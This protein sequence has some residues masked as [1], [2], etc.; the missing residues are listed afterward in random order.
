MF[1]GSEGGN[2]TK[3]RAA[4]TTSGALARDVAPQAP[5]ATATRIGMQHAN[6]RRTIGRSAIRED[7]SNAETAE[8]AENR[9]R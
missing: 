2:C 9:L 1:T 8:A 3:T 5:A 7:R 4:G 6:V